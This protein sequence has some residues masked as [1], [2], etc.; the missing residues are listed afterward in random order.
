M[1]QTLYRKY[2]PQTFSELVSQNHVKITLQ[3]EIETGQIAHAY[4]FCGPRGTGKTTAARLIAKAVNCLNLKPGQN[5]PCNVCESCREIIDG[6]SLDVI[7]IDAASHTGVDN[8]RENIIQNS[9]FVP[10][11]RKYKVFIIDEVH[12][13]SISAFNAL[14]KTLEEPPSHAIFILATTEPFK[15]PATI[16]SR[17]QR[18]D[19]KK[20]KSSELTA[21][22]QKIA[23]LENR[24]IDQVVLEQIARRADGSARDAESL[25]GQ[26]MSLGE[27]K[28]T[29][30]L[31]E[32]VM[33]I[34]DFNLVKNFIDFIIHQD[35]QS[36]LN[37]INRLVEDG[38]D[39]KI[40]TA[41]LIETL[42][43]ILLIKSGADLSQ[44]S[45]DLLS[46]QQAYLT[47]YANKLKIDE[48]LNMIEIFIDKK[49]ALKTADIPQFPLELAVIQLINKKSPVAESPPTAAVKLTE[50]KTAAPKKAQPKEGDL[51]VAKC[52]VIKDKNATVISCTLD[53]VTDKWSEILVKVK[54]Y[55]HT[56]F[57]FLRVNRPVAVKDNVVQIG[58]YYKFHLERISELKNRQILENILSEIIGAPVQVECVLVEHRSEQPGFVK[59]DAAIQN[60]MQEF[61][62]TIAK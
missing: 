19:F 9:R 30:E 23:K 34:S 39:L 13:L 33:P 10:S 2:R 49:Q 52:A 17:C 42:R 35:A 22:L 28:I 45:L 25:L 21:R 12:M 29:M 18:F 8:V 48:L 62:G 1:S 16:I 3:N 43:K 44:Y 40:F 31:A 56:L 54:E 55:N 36:A 51:A 38:L 6:K 47:E 11:R 32:L 59:E 57:S 37:L 26:V 24:D 4:L 46:E 5:E 7:E 60:L 20:V 27:K 14:L 58:V 41:D 53:F 61:G 15:L 50:N